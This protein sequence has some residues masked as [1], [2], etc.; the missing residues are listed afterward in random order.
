ET[1]LPQQMSRDE[2][3]VEVRKVIDEVGATGPQDMGKVMKPLMN[4]LKGRA[5]GKVINQIVRGILVE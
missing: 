2:I 3:E 4:R 5:D 1:Y